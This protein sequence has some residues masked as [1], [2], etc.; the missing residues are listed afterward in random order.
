[1]DFGHAQI[2]AGAAPYY[3]MEYI[4]G[5]S[6]KEVLAD[7]VLDGATFLTVVDQVLDALAYLHHEG[8]MH[9]D[10]KPENVLVRLDGAS[11]AA[12][13]MDLGVAKVINPPRSLGGALPLTTELNQRVVQV[14]PPEDD[15]DTTYFFST[16]R[17]TRDEWKKFLNGAVAR[18]EL[19]ELFPGHDL[20]AVG[21]LLKEAL[22]H[23]ELRNGIARD[24][25]EAGLAGV[26]TIRDGLLAPLGQERYGSATAVKE[27]WEKLDPGYLA[28]LRIPELAVGSSAATSLAT[29][30]GRVSISH[31]TQE[32]IAHPLFQRLRSIPQLEL[33]AL[34]YPGATHTRFLHSISVFDMARRYVSHLLNDPAFRLLV[35]RSEV[36]ATLLWALVHDIGHYPLSHMW[37][38]FAEE[39]QLGGKVRTIPTDDELM[40][41]FVS[42]EQLDPAFGDLAEVVESELR[43]RVF[44]RDKT[45]A[46][47]LADRY[48]SE[49][50]DAFCR[51]RKPSTLSES[52]LAGVMSSPIDADK[53]AYLT[54]DSRLTGVRYGLGIDIDALL[55]ALRAPRPEDVVVGVPTLAIADKGLTAAEG[56]VLARYWMIRRVYWHH[57]NRSV[58]AMTKHVIRGLVGNNLLTPGNYL[59]ETLFA[60][61]P[62][63]VSLLSRRYEHAASAGAFGDAG[64]RNPLL[65]LTDGQ[66]LLYKRLVTIA[67]GPKDDDEILYEKLAEL[68]V[69]AQG[70]LITEIS[71]RLSTR[72]GKKHLVLPGDVIFDVPTKQRESAPQK[73]LVYLQRDGDEGHALDEASPIIES[74]RA[75][76]DMH[77]KKS[78]VYVHPRLMARLEPHIAGAVSEVREALNGV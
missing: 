21:V 69:E 25:G 10:V 54:D 43:S 60:T 32:I 55:G 50:L 17:I 2:D 37:E 8:I 4:E 18:A 44:P 66:R 20:Y 38:D 51:L 77:A 5:R 16:P 13:L 24:L 53:V 75:E 73:T 23:K 42:P 76:F 62:E 3:V 1:M 26:R 57:A 64:A 58:I 33:A 65:G 46:E 11:V 71:E 70:D 27:D 48:S 67:R 12:T 15:V 14:M 68:S 72:I 29:P 74:L 59:R 61:A 28:P 31:R 63:A 34:V 78:R 39:E 41:A 35:S 40:W 47:L 30:G 22:D 45:L 52:V 9:S 7:D 49:T 36:E 6:L 56:I 19:I